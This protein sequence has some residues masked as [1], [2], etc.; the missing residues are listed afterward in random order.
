MWR[1]FASLFLTFIA[2]GWATIISALCF[3]YGAA[4][5]GDLFGRDWAFYG[6]LIAFVFCFLGARTLLRWADRLLEPYT[7]P[8]DERA[9]RDA[10]RETFYAD[11]QRYAGDIVRNRR[12]AFYAR[13]RQWDKLA[14]LESQVV[15]AGASPGPQ[16]E[17]LQPARTSMGEHLPSEEVSRATRRISVQAPRIERWTVFEEYEVEDAEEE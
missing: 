12:Y 14:A 5:W 8:F 11:W 17:V 2:L 7:G 9:Y 10:P 16:R 13:T 6:A 15:A 3:F 4:L 1:A